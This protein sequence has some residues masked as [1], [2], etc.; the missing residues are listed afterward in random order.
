MINFNAVFNDYTLNIFTDAS[1][2]VCANKLTC[3]CSGAISTVNDKIIK[4]NIRVLK[5]STNNLGEITAILLG[6]EDAFLYKNS[7]KTINLFSDS[8]INIFGLREWIFSW[9]NASHKG[10]LYSSTGKEVANQNIILTIINFI[11]E[12]NLNINL[13][14]Q[15][16]HVSLN[17]VNDL[18]DAR[19]NF[20]KFNG[21][22]NEV[23]MNIIKQI[24]FFNNYID[25]HTRL[26]LNN[27]DIIKMP[28]T[29][30]AIKMVY[31]PFDINNYKSLININ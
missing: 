18:I 21:I 1:V 10:V 7:F 20:N 30:L 6:V 13:Y 4:T 31:K 8:K 12:N 2:K 27:S 24:S 28:E 15:N 26:I 25:N 16:G 9:I 22:R 5:N 19:N 23:D 3:T 29:K 17:N 14:H 11:L